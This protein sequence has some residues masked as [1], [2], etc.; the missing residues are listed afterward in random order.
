VVNE[1]EH[2]VSLKL[3]YG[4]NNPGIAVINIGPNGSTDTY[5]YCYRGSGARPI[6]PLTYVDYT[7]VD[8]LEVIF[9]DTHS[10]WYYWCYHYTNGS[11]TSCVHKS[12]LTDV[13]FEPLPGQA[14]AFIYRITEADYQQALEQHFS[15]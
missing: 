8:S 9:N 12:P 15:K 14:N 5:E 1:T 11:C 10:L 13:C 3:H 6:S 7:L 2:R 4:N